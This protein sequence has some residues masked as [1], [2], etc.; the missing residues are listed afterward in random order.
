MCLSMISALLGEQKYNSRY[1]QPRHYMEL[2]SH[3]LSGSF[4]HVD[5]TTGTQWTRGRVC[6]KIKMHV[7]DKRQNILLPPESNHKLSTAHTIAL[8]LQWKIHRGFNT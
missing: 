8:S 7:L 6:V 2:C 4:T 5:W 1:S 3:L